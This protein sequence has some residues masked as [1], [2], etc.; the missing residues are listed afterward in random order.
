MNKMM[1]Y[2][3]S[4]LFVV[5]M[6][7]K[8]QMI[9][10]GGGVVGAMEAYFSWQDS[11]KN[12]QDL[13]VSIY[14]KNKT[15]LGTTCLHIVP[16]L[17]P[18]E[19]LSVVPRGADLVRKLKI[20]FSQPGGIRVDDVAGID[21]SEVTEQFKT[22]VSMYSLDQEGHQQRTQALLAL[23]KMSMN[24]W[25]EI[26]DN[27]DAEFQEILR[28]ANF[29]PCKE[30]DS[31]DKILHDG[32]RIDLIYHVDSAYDRA[33]SMKKDYQD[34]GY[35]QCEI[36]TP[37]EVINIDPFLT[38]FCLMHS[39]KND[40]GVLQWNNDAV[41][42][43]RPGGCL[44]L[45][46]LLPKLYDYLT[47]KMGAEHFQVKF[48]K[49]ICKADF[50]KN[51]TGQTIISALYCDDGTVV[52]P[53][54]ND[55]VSYVFCPGEAVGTL[56]NLGFS[57]PVYAGFAGPSLML[58]IDIPKQDVA[59]YQNFNHCMEVHQEGVVLAWQ[60]R[61]KDGKI[62]IGVAGTKAFYGDQAPHKDQAFAKNRN[63]LQL[64]MIN[65]V[66]PECISWA[67]GYDTKGQI[68]TEQDLEYLEAKTVA[69]RWVGV[70]SVA[71]DGFPT[72]GCI[73]H[74]GDMVGNARCTTH[75]GSGGVSF[76]PAAV[77]ISRSIMNTQ[78]YD[79]F[80]NQILQY[81]DSARRA[82]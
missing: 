39:Q 2:C 36:L 35:S 43:W 33:L 56:K 21:G 12:N 26:Y 78:T 58:N 34:L 48:G 51:N 45:P 27:A 18:D 11:V 70:R 55:S 57:E 1:T 61:V 7:A 75:L 37:E 14:E 19:I 73:Y 68:L 81:A 5:S 3:L 24:L 15:I 66:L 77:F 6:Y 32:Y 76:A 17:T 52:R 47:E 60:A 31:N 46:V 29:N 4:L 16:S 40:H 69:L 79:S 63:L 23:G 9:I 28:T 82:E 71:Y 22:A 80:V 59:R 49:K 42:L 53:S 13:Y 64:N 25:Q 62:F 44:D 38:D 74:D 30:S 54:L 72:L 10:V 41:A 50:E 67:C 20:L 8:N 65:D